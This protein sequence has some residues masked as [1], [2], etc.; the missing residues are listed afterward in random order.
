MGGD[1]SGPW[2]AANPTLP[3]KGVKSLPSGDDLN[4]TPPLIA[5]LGDGVVIAG[6][7]SDAKLAGLDKLEEGVK[8]EAFVARLDRSGKVLWSKPLPDAGMPNAIAVSPDGEVVVLASFLP[9]LE[10][11]SPSFYGDSAY[12][13]KLGASGSFVYEKELTFPLS[14]RAHALTVDGTGQ[15]YVGGSVVNPDVI[16]QEDA[17]LAKYDAQGEEVFYHPFEHD[18][19][20]CILNNLSMLPNGDIVGVGTFNGTVDFGGGALSTEAHLEQYSMPNGFVARFSSS[21]AHVF[22]QRFGGDVFDTGVAVHALPDGDF[23]LGGALSGSSSVGGKSVIVTDEGAAF[24]ARLDG[25]GKA[26]WLQTLPGH[27]TVWGLT[28]DADGTTV[29]AAGNFGGAFLVEYDA[30]G[31]KL[32]ELSP[33][34]PSSGPLSSH[35][36]AVDSGGGVWVSGSFQDAVNFGNDNALSSARA[37][38]YLLRLFRLAP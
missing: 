7:T 13:A 6:A 3:A 10:A 23:L 25:A 18:A 29:H 26:R 34:E 5:Q 4:S 16:G 22:S 30:T 20:T 36:V 11:V 31:K 17:F 2:G 28:A 37:G 14:P 21:G 33:A 12:L 15:V 9:S 19:S 8:S 35:S 32:A 24:V 38:V 1:S 27:G